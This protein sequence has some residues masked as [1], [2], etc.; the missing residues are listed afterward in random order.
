MSALIKY[1][2]IREQV[3]PIIRKMIMMG[4][5]KPGDRITEQAIAD[6]LHI[7]RAPIREAFREIESRGLI[8]WS[9]NKGCTVAK[10]SP[11]DAWE[12]FYLRCSLEIMSIERVGGAF[13]QA[14]LKT[15]EK[16]LKAMEQDSKNSDSFA[17]INA[18]EDFHGLIVR[19]CGMKRL[20][21]LWD[22][23][24]DLNCALFLTE[25]RELCEIGNQYDRHLK[26]FDALASSGGL[27]QKKAAV[28]FHYNEAIQRIAFEE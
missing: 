3:T 5:L 18:D 6:E 22:S 27:E 1:R 13:K 12:V 4:K 17:F 25:N 14:T 11:R 8:N 19:E 23:L 16:I 20:F 10:L 21:S 28:E 7:S 26:L 9:A 15:M 2:S 24:S